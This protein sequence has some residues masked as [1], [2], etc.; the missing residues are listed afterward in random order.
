MRLLDKKSVNSQLANQKAQQIKEGLTLAKKVDALRETKLEEEKQLEEFRKGSIAR[1]QIEIDSKSLER[2][3]LEKSLIP[4]REEYQR[5][6][7]PPDLTQAWADVK[8]K[9]QEVQI[10]YLLL[11][12]GQSELQNVFALVEKRETMCEAEAQRISVLKTQAENFLA[13]S[14][15]KYTQSI[16]ILERAKRDGERLMEEARIAIAHL[17]TRAQQATEREVYVTSEEKRIRAW[18]VDLA[19]REKKL[20]VN[21][22]IFIKSKD[23]LKKKNV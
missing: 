11:S 12:Q 21:Q 15:I 8:K 3:R 4:M 7:T 23:Y 5:L 9:E 14:E 10:K 1:V 19:A 2:D 16:D 6:L 20:K 18:E 13:E 22:Q 17:E